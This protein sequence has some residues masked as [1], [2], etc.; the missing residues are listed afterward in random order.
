[1]NH[2][3]ALP[4]L[5]ILWS[6]LLV[7]AEEL[8][9]RR[10][11]VLTNEA[12]LVGRIEAKT[13]EFEVKTD[14]GF[15]VIPANRVLKLCESLEDAHAFLHKRLKPN[16]HLDQLRL[17]RWCLKYGLTEQAKCEAEAILKLQP[18]NPEALRLLGRTEAAPPSGEPLP[19]SKAEAI[20]TIN[21][22]HAYTPE[23]LRT[24]SQRVQPLLFNSCATGA[25][26]GGGKAT[27]F[28]LQRPASG[29]LLLPNV[30]R[31]NLVQTLKLIER[32]DAS[33]SELLR[34][35]LE[36]HGGSAKP[37]L[38]GKDAPA[39]Q[40]LEAWV[41]KAA[42]AKAA[43]SLSGEIVSAAPRPSENQPTKAKAEPIDRPKL[44]AAL[45]DKFAALP[46]APAT[47]EGPKESPVAEEKPKVVKD[48]RGAKPLTPPDDPFDP[49]QFNEQY[50]PRKK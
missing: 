41:L 48:P 47:E 35:A 21:H 9:P 5:L 20:S 40:T 3:R 7:H 36:A 32:E 16:D 50:H 37:P 1:M 8:P 38:T 28:E 46:M 29:G 13:G 10:V 39:Y 44:P 34:K 2:Y 4:I 22:E 23:T 26:H 24:F 49:V 11:L 12:T 33:Q 43:P 19:T 14:S 6:P 30:T 15:S 25:C 42:P 31:Q 18:K 27:G 17:M 45:E